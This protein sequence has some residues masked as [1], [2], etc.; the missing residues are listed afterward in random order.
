MVLACNLCCPAGIGPLDDEF[1]MKSL[2]ASQLLYSGLASA[3]LLRQD[4]ASYCCT[5]FNMHQQQPGDVDMPDAAAT[6]SNHASPNNRANGR[7]SSAAATSL[8]GPAAHCAANS[9]SRRAAAAARVAAAAAAAGA[10]NNGSSVRGIPG[11]VCCECG[12][13]QTPQW[14]EGPL[15]KW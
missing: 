15:G 13:T 14:R 6:G 3:Q 4:Y 1:G 2:N 11:K 7:N 8:S 5:A 10:S 9:R 12:A